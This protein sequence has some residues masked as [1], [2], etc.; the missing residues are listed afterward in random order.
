M[1][2]AIIPEGLYAVTVHFGS[3]EEIGPTRDRWVNEWL[4]E[5]GWLTDPSRPNY[6][7]PNPFGYPA[8]FTIS[9]NSCVSNDRSFDITV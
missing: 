7:P 5:S 9:S 6:E 8:A 4:P 3:S 1:K 2:E